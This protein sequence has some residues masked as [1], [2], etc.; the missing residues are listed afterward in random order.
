MGTCAVNDAVIEPTVLI[1]SDY[2]II[3]EIK[4]NLSRLF[5]FCPE[6]DNYLRQNVFP[7]GRG[8]V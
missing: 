8:H 6:S 5:H 7:M 4:N 1:V 2:L 3:N